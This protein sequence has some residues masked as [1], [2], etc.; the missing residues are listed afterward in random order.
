MLKINTLLRNK[1]YQLSPALNLTYI[2]EWQ[3]KCFF[4]CVSK[5]FQIILNNY[6][7]KQNNSKCQ[8]NTKYLNNKCSIRYRKG[9]CL[10]PL[11]VY[12]SINVKTV[13]FYIYYCI[14]FLYF[15]RFSLKK[16]TLKPLY[17]ITKFN[18]IEHSFLHPCNRHYIHF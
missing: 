13:K 6:F 5:F 14:A 17:L 1:P 16:I 10:C 15:R 4:Y 9:R 11:V 12:I 18:L 2:I 3:R 8:N 7:Y